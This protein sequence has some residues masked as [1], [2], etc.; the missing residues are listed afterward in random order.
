[1]LT[2]NSGYDLWVV[3]EYGCGMQVLVFYQQQSAVRE[4]VLLLSMRG[5]GSAAYYK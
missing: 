3:V 4:G 2:I 5:M 1:M